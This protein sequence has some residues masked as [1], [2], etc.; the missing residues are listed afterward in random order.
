MFARHG[1]D[2]FSISEIVHINL[3]QY[4]TCA[5]MICGI[6]LLYYASDFSIVVN[7]S[8]KNKGTFSSLHEI[9]INIRRGVYMAIPTTSRFRLFRRPDWVE[10]SL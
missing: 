5:Q 8:T 10:S 6:R 4:I 7:Y 2:G 1:V 9:R 3:L